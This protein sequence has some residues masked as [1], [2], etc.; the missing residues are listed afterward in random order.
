VSG[1][2][3]RIGRQGERPDQKIVAAGCCDVKDNLN[4]SGSGQAGKRYRVNAVL[5][6][7]GIDWL[8]VSDS[9]LYLRIG[10]RLVRG[11]VVE[12]DR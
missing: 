3:L 10:D 11:E 1:T 4:R 8:G 2:R 9:D 5:R 12:V 7:L 6:Q